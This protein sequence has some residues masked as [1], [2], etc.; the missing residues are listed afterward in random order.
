MQQ[1]QEKEKSQ[2]V[3]VGSSRFK[4]TGRPSERHHESEFLV[5]MRIVV[6]RKY[7]AI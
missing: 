5:T 1:L 4:I 2:K 6:V 7:K 3:V